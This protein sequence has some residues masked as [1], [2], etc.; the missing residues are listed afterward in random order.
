MSVLDMLG[1]IVAF[2]FILALQQLTTGIFM[3]NMWRAHTEDERRLVEYSDEEDEF[4]IAIC[5][6]FGSSRAIV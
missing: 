4:A 3:S 6:F 1:L 2:A 5:C